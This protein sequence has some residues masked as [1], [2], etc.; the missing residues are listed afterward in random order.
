[1]SNTLFLWSEVAKK[2]APSLPPKDES[3]SDAAPEHHHPARPEVKKP[4]SEPSPEP[5]HPAPSRPK[6]PVAGHKPVIPPK[7][8]LPAQKKPKGLVKK[9]E[10]KVETAEDNTSVYRKKSA[11]D[12]KDRV[13]GKPLEK[14]TPP[15]IKTESAEEGTTYKTLLVMY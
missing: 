15:T 4:S 10:K 12:T 13:D 2:P 6:P 9:P 3:D 11:E 14:E 8:P 7:K 5:S 1:M